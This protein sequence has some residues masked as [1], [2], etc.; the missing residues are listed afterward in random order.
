MARFFDPARGGWRLRC[1]VPGCR[2][3]YR[4]KPQDRHT[5][6]ICG[7]HWRSADRGLRER[8]KRLKRATRLI[9]R[10]GGDLGYR[11]AEAN[12]RAYLAVWLDAQAA[13]MACLKDAAIK[14]AMGAHK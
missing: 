11:T 2:R 3:S 10:R 1:S 14:E 9:E 8:H 4:G 12:Q 6:V 5:V 7:R 13:W